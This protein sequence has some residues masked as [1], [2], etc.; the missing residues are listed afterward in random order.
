MQK[1][2]DVVIPLNGS[3]ELCRFVFSVYQNWEQIHS[4][5]VYECFDL[6]TIDFL[7]SFSKELN[8]HPE[9]RNYPDLVTLA[10]FCRKAN[11]KSYSQKN[12]GSDSLKVGRGT[13]FHIAPSNVPVNFAYSLISGLLSGNNNIVKVPSQ[14]FD[15]VRII[16]ETLTKLKLEGDYIDQLE[17]IVLVQYDRSSQLTGLF[18]QNASVRIIW[19]GDETIKKVRSFSIPPRSFDLTFADRYSICLLQAD[20]ILGSSNLKDLAQKFFNDTFLFDQNA[21]TAPH[22]VVWMGSENNISSAKNKFWCELDKYCLER[23]YHVAPTNIID[24]LTKSYLIASERS[25]CVINQSERIVRVELDELDR[26]MEDY[27]SS[28]G[29]FIEASISELNEL[30]R[31]ITPK[32]QTLVY[33][34]LSKENI[35]KFIVNSGIKGVDRV[36]PVGA[37]SDFS[38]IWDGYDIINILSRSIE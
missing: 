34:G 10:F 36:V 19:G 24:K 14:P 9:T 17:R 16:A 29:F 28:C 4:K 35:S 25:V 26:S 30:N 18:S 23:N 31:V 38:L 8:K 7:N 13:I 2:E 3:D 21:C 15:Q 6:R 11:L 37:A 20:A 32:Y 22:L 33:F 1:Y 27:R 5:Q 12:Q